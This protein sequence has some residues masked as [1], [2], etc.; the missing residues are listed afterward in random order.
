MVGGE[1]RIVTRGPAR[2][3]RRAVARASED[4]SAR[5][6]RE[7]TG[8]ACRGEIVHGLFARLPR[9]TFCDEPAAA[10]PFPDAGQSR[11][12]AGADL[13]AAGSGGRRQRTRRLAM[14]DDAATV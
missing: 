8:G 3:T 10:G 6:P 7:R 1:P 4:T 14:G 11:R 5:G 13:C 9:R 2:K 12:L